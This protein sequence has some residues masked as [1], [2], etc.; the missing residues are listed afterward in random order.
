MSYA[1]IRNDKLTR[2]K[3]MGAY[4][5]NERKAKN[6]SNQNIDSSKT[7]LNYYIK[8]NE[9]SYIKEFDRIKENYNLKGQIR[10][11]SIIMCEMIFTSD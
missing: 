11:N 2:A 6:H 4:M 9:L 3:A 5:H 1:I 7:E 8:K 10:S